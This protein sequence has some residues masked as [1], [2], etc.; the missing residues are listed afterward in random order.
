MSALKELTFWWDGVW[1]GDQEEAVLEHGQETTE[2]W[3]GRWC[4]GQ[5]KRMDSGYVLEVKFTGCA[6]R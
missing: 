3:T 4:G 6:D 2:P 1:D 5:E